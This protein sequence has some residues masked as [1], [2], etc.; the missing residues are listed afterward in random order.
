MPPADRLVAICSELRVS[1]DA[2]LGLPPRS[3]ETVYGN[4]FENPPR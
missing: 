4:D 2:I 3:R 1:A